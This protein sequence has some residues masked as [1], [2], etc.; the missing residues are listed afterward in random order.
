MLTPRGP[1]KR[2]SRCTRI[3]PVT[4]S[5][6]RFSPSLEELREQIDL[7][8]TAW[9]AER[10]QALPDGAALIEI[11]ASVLRSGGKRLRPAFCFWGYRAAGG[12]DDRI[13]R[14]A[15]SLEL[16][17]TFAIVHDDIMDA[18]QTRRGESTVHAKHGVEVGVLAGDLAL[19]LAD[20]M[21]MGADFDPSILYRA[22]THYSR[23][24]E[25]VIAG[26]F[27]DM[28]AA[29][30]DAID[31]ST[32][33]RIAILKSGRYTIVEPLLIG[34]ELAA[35]DAAFLA[36][37]ERF[38]IPL[39]E[40]FQLNDDLLGTFGDS[41][42]TG[43]SVD[44]DIREGKRNVLFV[45]TRDALVGAQREFFVSNWGGGAALDEATI[46]ELRV[47]VESSGARRA[48]EGLVRE[49]TGLALDA[50]RSAS[51]PG[52]AGGALLD[53]AARATSR[54]D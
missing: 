7:T 47:L 10:T 53:L 20:A 22:F 3:D 23:M 45:K 52:E 12:D 19:V 40:A 44:S 50:L 34:A 6:R 1:N 33:R 35:G 27:L 5:E 30:S 17:H 9:L 37:L 13:V 42:D 16:L 25:Q 21:F 26:Q 48:T 54:T 32:A 14:A 38:G 31:E 8:L 43:K 18:A 49:L 4:P 2:S 29:R 41:E 46:G 15:A 28:T 39:G 11:V 36:R 24:R 51:L